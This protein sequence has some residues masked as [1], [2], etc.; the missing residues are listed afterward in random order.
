MTEIVALVSLN[1]N[2]LYYENLYRAA[3]YK[4]IR[5]GHKFRSNVDYKVFET[6]PQVHAKA[7]AI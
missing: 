4:H 6:E 2:V 3:S 1:T 5:K 7:F